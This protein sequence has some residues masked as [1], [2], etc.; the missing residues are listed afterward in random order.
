MPAVSS[1]LLAS[2]KSVETRH[3][4]IVNYDGIVPEI[5]VIQF[6]SAFGSPFTVYLLDL[7]LFDFPLPESGIHSLPTFRRNL[8]TFTFS[9]PTPFQLLILP[10]RISLST[11]PD[12]SKT[13]ALYKSFTYLLTYLSANGVSLLSS[14]MW[15]I[16]MRQ[17]RTFP[18][19]S[20]VVE[21]QMDVTSECTCGLGLFVKPGNVTE[22]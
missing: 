16:H 12:S 19:S 22:F 2:A 9:Q 10:P 8:K 14:R 13:S 4:G 15:S 21:R 3:N 6:S 17:R 1:T 18:L 20:A 5:W 11:R 7:V